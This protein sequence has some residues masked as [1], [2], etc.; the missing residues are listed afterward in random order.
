MIRDPAVDDEIR[1]E[2]EFGEV[3]VQLFVCYPILVAEVPICGHI[4]SK[5]NLSH[6]ASSMMLDEKLKHQLYLS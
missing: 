6:N 2:Q 3:C 1:I 5:N 4:N